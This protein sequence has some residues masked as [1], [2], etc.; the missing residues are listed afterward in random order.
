MRALGF[1]AVAAL[2]LAACDETMMMPV[3]GGGG[4]PAAPVRSFA[5]KVAS[6]DEAVASIGCAMV[7]ES[8]YMAVEFQ[9]DLTREESTTITAQKLAAGKAVKLP[10]GGARI[11]DGACAA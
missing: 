11:T 8:D 9:A 7:G 10:E 3:T 4:A 2:A 6:Y 1:L 5:D